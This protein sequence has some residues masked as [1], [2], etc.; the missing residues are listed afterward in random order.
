MR[1]LSKVI[2]FVV[3]ELVVWTLAVSAQT[4]GSMA[5]Q[6]VCWQQ[7]RDYVVARNKGDKINYSFE[8]AHYDATTKTC[9]VQYGT[10]TQLV[11]GF[12]TYFVYVDDAFEGKTFAL[13]VGANHLESGE[14]KEDIPTS[15]QVNGKECKERTVFNGM[16]WKFIPAFRPV[17]AVTV[18]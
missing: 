2:V 4:R 7:A 3:I 1:K 10:V 8:Q 13:F 18:K 11:E 16:L 15:C 12:L 17:N 5:E 6:Q 14:Y 9:Y